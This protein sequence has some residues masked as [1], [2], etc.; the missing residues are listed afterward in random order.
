M[1]LFVGYRTK[2]HLFNALNTVIRDLSYREFL[3]LK[4]TQSKP[5]LSFRISF[6]NPLTLLC[7]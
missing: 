4:W 7:T 1:I 5:G 6:N 3:Q 2:K